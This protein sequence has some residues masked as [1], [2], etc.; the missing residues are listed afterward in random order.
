MWG[1]SLSTE[2]ITPR[3]ILDYITNPQSMKDLPHKKSNK[4]TINIFKFVEPR[5]LVGPQRI[6]Q[7]PPGWQTRRTYTETRCRNLY[8]LLYQ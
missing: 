1:D 8:T 3:L 7:Y 5:V 6:V 2:M 4:I